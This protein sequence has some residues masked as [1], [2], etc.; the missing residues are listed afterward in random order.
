MA[1][2]ETI[3]SYKATVPVLS[4]NVFGDLSAKILT[5]AQDL[6]D[7]GYNANVRAIGA[8]GVGV[9]TLQVIL[10]KRGSG[11]GTF[12]SFYKS[13]ANAA[14]AAAAAHASLNLAAITDDMLEVV[15]FAAQA[16]GTSVTAVENLAAQAK[17]KYN[18]CASKGGWFCSLNALGVPSWAI[19]GGIGVGAIVILNNLANVKRTLLG[20]FDRRREGSEGERYDWFVVNKTTGEVQAGNEYRED[21]VDAAN[22]MPGGKSSFKVTHRSKVDPRARAKFFEDNP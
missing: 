21:A 9:N 17:Q 5:V 4:L 19:W 12:A 18:E 15:A 2:A 11:P 13:G 16:P 14:V 20:G 22:D 3:T 1:L 8:R 6:T 7:A 10:T